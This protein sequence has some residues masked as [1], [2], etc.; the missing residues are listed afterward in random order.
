MQETDAPPT[1]AARKHLFRQAALDGLSAT[2]DLDHPPT[3]AKAGWR[4][5]L[6]GLALA[7]AVA[8]LVLLAPH[9]P[10]P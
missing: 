4:V 2:E 3:L 7:C 6:L 8:A 5:W 1:P 9:L 10:P